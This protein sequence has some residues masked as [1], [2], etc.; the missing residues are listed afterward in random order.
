M[1][2]IL[3]IVRNN[4]DTEKAV[5]NLEFAGYKIEKVLS[6]A[7][8]I[9]VGDSKDLIGV[10]KVEGIQSAQWNDTRNVQ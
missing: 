9:Y 6:R 2:T 5:D 1:T 8:I 4:F 3:A 7:G 10:G